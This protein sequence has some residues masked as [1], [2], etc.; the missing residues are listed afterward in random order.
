MTPLLLAPLIKFLASFELKPT[1]GFSIGEAVLGVIILMLYKTRK[2]GPA[3]NEYYFG[4]KLALPEDQKPNK[5]SINSI[6]ASAFTGTTSSVHQAGQPTAA[7]QSAN[8]SGNVTT[9]DIEL[10]TF[11]KGHSGPAT[12]GASPNDP[13]LPA[14]GILRVTPSNKPLN[15][16]RS[17]CSENTHANRLYPGPRLL[18]RRNPLPT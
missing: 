2:T 7:T 14:H 1:L 12:A 3:E 11:Q 18:R 6:I 9:Q 10:Q 17:A 13:S 4:M 15:L 8:T 16:T 5:E